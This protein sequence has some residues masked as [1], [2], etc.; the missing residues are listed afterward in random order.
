MSIATAILGLLGLLIFLF[1]IKKPKKN[2]PPGKTFKVKLKFI[3]N[4]VL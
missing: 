4:L 3:F 2:E 1:S